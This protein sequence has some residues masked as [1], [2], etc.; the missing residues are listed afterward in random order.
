ML[1]RLTC[2]V[3]LALVIALCLSCAIASADATVKVAKAFVWPTK[4]A[5]AEGP[6]HQP[7]GNVYLVDPEGRKL[8][9]TTKG[10]CALIR[11]FPDNRTVAWIEG[12]CHHLEMDDSWCTYGK[13]VIYRDGKVIR[14]IGSTVSD[15]RFWDHGTR[16]ATVNKPMDGTCCLWKVSNGD[17]VAKHVMHWGQT[18]ASLPAWAK[19]LRVIVGD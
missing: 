8:Q 4:C 2:A 19:G 5:N 16:V 3:A 12:D 17:L 13:L 18:T 9:V 15:W 11:L 1:T 10:N 14:K 7:H 6:M